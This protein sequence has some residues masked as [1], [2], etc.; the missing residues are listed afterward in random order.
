MDTFSN[1]KTNNFLPYL[2]AALHAKK[3]RLNDC[4]LLNSQNQICDTTMANIFCIREGI[5]YTP[6][7]TEGCIAG[8]MRRW[9]I[10]Q[11][12]KMQWKL[13]EKSISTDELH[14]AE[15]VFLTNSIYGIRWVQS[16]GNTSYTG[17][18]TERL[19]NQLIPA[20]NRV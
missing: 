15:E 8:V 5:L 4:V 6:A 3:N 17:H 7:L 14:Q 19:F 1:C 9:L 20:L 11:L 18:Q 16:F 12:Q 10:T 2:M 13:V